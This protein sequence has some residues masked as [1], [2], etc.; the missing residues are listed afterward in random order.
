M[1]S[2]K[3]LVHLVR[4]PQI[5]TDK[6]PVLF[7]LHGIGS[8]EYDLFGLAQILDPR[9]QVIS[10]RAPLTLQPDSY[11]WFEVQFTGQGPVAN[12]RQALQSG[13]MMVDFMN[14]ATAAY[15]GD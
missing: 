15:G 13:H 7:L 8:N 5:Q 9:W 4:S 2:A 11:A 14:E 12:M 6:P 10:V 1:G 3:S